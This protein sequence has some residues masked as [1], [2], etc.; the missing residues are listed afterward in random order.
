MISFRDNINV[1]SGRG[2]AESDVGGRH[3]SGLEEWANS[4]L[5]D[6]GQNEQLLIPNTMRT[7]WPG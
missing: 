4:G 7:L 1:W 6:S 3:D 5:D 2:L